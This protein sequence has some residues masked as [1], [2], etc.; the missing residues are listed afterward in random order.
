MIH[1]LIGHMRGCE[2]GLPV[3]APDLPGYG[4]M[5]DS[6]AEITLPG[7]VAYLHAFLKKQGVKSAHLIG[8]SVGG[9]IAMLFAAAHPQMVAS[10]TSVEGN[11][12]LKDAFWSKAI[13]HMPLAEIER[14][15]QADCEN[16]QVWLERSGVAPT[17]LRLA[18]ALSHLTN[19]PASTVQATARSVVQ[20]TGARQYLQTVRSVLEA[21]TPV[22]LIAGQRSRDAWD[23]PGFVVAKARKLSVLER[24]GHLITIESPAEFNA[25]CASNLRAL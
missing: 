1:G 19:Q 15:L 6:R 22:F 7:Q 5:R 25:T 14:D 21:G 18:D 2:V 10:V 23:V 12:T 20:I 16:P 11:F 24:T 4:S 9:A 8:H 3:L 13:S 17:P